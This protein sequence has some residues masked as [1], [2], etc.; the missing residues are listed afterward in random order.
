MLLTKNK[1]IACAVF[2]W[3]TIQLSCTRKW[4]DHN[5]INDT[6]LTQNLYETIAADESLSKF[7]SYLQKTGYADT[8]QLNRMFTVWAPTNDALQTI[9]AAISGNDATLKKFV[10]HHI[11]HLSYYSNQLQSDT[12]RLPLID[13]KYVAV[14]PAFF[15]DAPID[16]KDRPAANGVLHTIT[17]A[18]APVGNCWDYLDSLKAAGNNMASYIR[19]RV[20][21]KRDTTHAIQIGIDPQT[22]AP[23]YQKGTDTVIRN[24]FLD[25]VYD[26]SNEAKQYTVFI[27]NNTVW[28]K[29]RARLDTFCKAT[30]VDSVLSLARLF[31]AKD[32]LIE[33][34]YAPDQL[35][36]SV[37]SKFGVWVPINKSAI[38]AKYRTSNGYVYVMNDMNVQLRQ[39]ITPIIIQGENYA[40]TSNS[41]YSPIYLRTLINPNNGQPF[42][43]LYAYSHGVN[44][45]N[46][47]YR[48]YNVYTTK[49][50][51]YWTTYNNRWNN[52]LNQRL[53]M[54]TPDN[55]TFAY[56]NVPYNVYDSVYLGDYTVSTYGNGILD[57]YLVSA[58]I[59]PSSSN[60]NQSALFLDYIRLEPVIQ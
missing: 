36:D 43:D 17:A 19:G 39:R 15:D 54:G 8:L 10:A 13:G 48:I 11:A 21:P 5:K 9:D 60:M 44:K 27:M 38:Q 56:R 41:S 16:T 20:Y 2:L 34:A 28:D 49:Y 3:C 22:G 40:G 55:T 24:T 32:M 59:S 58:D 46:V 45:W 4:D 29:E 42:K 31:T 33:G 37:L 14:K 52:T 26:I 7:T 30:T 23:V 25:E 35:P 51:V 53:A 57:L 47:R 50:R 6:G 1:L 12:I 18:T